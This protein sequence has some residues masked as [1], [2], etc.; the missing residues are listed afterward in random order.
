MLVN[1]SE[2]HKQNVESSIADVQ[3]LGT[4]SQ[5]NLVNKILE[6]IENTNVGDYTELIRDLR[7]SLRDELKLD[8]ISSEV[9]VIMF[10]TPNTPEERGN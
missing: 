8:P 7:N 1:S 6:E 5:I 2:E 3:L 10:N 4:R 9:Q